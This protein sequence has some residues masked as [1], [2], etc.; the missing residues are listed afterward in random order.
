MA[1]TGKKSKEL[2]EE[3]ERMRKEIDEEYNQEMSRYKQGNLNAT[4]DSVNFSYDSSV[5]L[6]D[7]GRTRVT[8]FDPKSSKD[9]F[10]RFQSEREKRLG[11]TKPVSY[12]VRHS[13]FYPSPY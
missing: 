6:F 13:P 7:I 5:P 10:Y 2:E 11:N 12:T 4:N 3:I 1:R 9:T 8:Q